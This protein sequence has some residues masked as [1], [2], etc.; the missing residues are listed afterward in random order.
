MT[1][2]ETFTLPRVADVIALLRELQGDID[3]DYRADEDSDEPGM[4]ITIGASADGSWSYQT[5]DNSYTGGAYRHPV[6]G[7]GTL[8]QA[9]DDD[10]IRRLA[11]DLVSQIGDQTCEDY[12]LVDPD[13]TEN[14]GR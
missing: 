4:C 13:D 3:D 9:D 2:K 7:V 6:W 12:E 1:T 14:P 5:G 10:A 11:E 8:L